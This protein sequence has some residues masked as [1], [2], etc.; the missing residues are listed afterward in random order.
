MEHL[1]YYKGMSYLKGNICRPDYDQNSRRW[2]HYD[3]NFSNTKITPNPKLGV[4]YL[5]RFIANPGRT[6]N[7]P[8]LVNTA[9]NEVGSIKQQIHQVQQDK[10]RKDL[11]AKYK[12]MAEDGGD[13]AY[14]FG[15]NEGLQWGMP[16]FYVKNKFKELTQIKIRGR[17]PM[18]KNIVMRISSDLNLGQDAI[19]ISLHKTKLLV[20]STDENTGLIAVAEMPQG[21]SV[22][23]G[24]R[25]TLKKEFGECLESNGELFKRNLAWKIFPSKFEI[26]GESTVLKAEKG[27]VKK[28]AIIKSY[29]IHELNAVE[30]IKRAKQAALIAKA[31]NVYDYA[32]FSQNDSALG[33]VNFHEYIKSDFPGLVEIVDDMKFRNSIARTDVIREIADNFISRELYQEIPA[34]YT[35]KASNILYNLNKGTFMV[36]DPDEL[37]LP[38]MVYT[39]NTDLMA[40]LSK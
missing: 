5:E 19:T 10:Q 29:S 18:H 6:P 17:N 33:L 15:R 40:K 16:L 20:F 36:V 7:S 4:A 34:G 23:G 14:V 13:G 21:R 2:E 32:N 31:I 24:I 37:A 3:N 26:K 9:R 11:E 30:T 8:R 38:N 22:I 12:K 39:M 1:D 25:S 35:E 27:N 28:L